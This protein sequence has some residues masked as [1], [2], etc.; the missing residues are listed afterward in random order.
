MILTSKP[1]VY[2]MSMPDD[3]QHTLKIF[4][5]KSADTGEMMV[6][7]SNKHGNDSCTFNVEMAGKQ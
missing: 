2:E 3:D 1:G 4:K 6:M 5:V 7:A